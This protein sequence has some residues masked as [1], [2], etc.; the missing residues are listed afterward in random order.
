MADAPTALSVTNIAHLQELGCS[1]TVS[2][3][4]LRETRSSVLQLRTS[5]PASGSSAFRPLSGPTTAAMQCLLAP[6]RCM[7]GVCTLQTD[8]VAPVAL[9]LS[10]LFVERDSRQRIPRECFLRSYGT[11]SYHLVASVSAVQLRLTLLAPIWSSRRKSTT[12]TVA[13]LLFI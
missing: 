7:G 11:C 4:I 13:A 3:A 6:T 10:R 5:V 8:R 1:N 12:F 2:N 9:P